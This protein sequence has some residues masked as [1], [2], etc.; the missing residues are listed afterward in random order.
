MDVTRR[1]A[2]LCCL[3]MS[4][5]PVKIASQVPMSRTE[6][7]SRRTGKHFIDSWSQVDVADAF[8][9]D[10]VEEADDCRSLHGHPDA[11]SVAGHAQHCPLRVGTDGE[12][13]L[14]QG[15]FN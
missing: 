3:M 9:S 12:L 11:Q 14:E 10:G 8:V 1:Q 13:I 5:Q 4:S 6:W 7:G 2:A 15:K